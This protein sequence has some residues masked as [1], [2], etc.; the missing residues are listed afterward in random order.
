MG[1]QHTSLIATLGACMMAL[2][3]VHAQKDAKTSTLTAQ[4]Y[5]AIQQLAHRYAYAL[6]T[7]ADNGLMYANLFARD[8]SFGNTKGREALAT[9]AW[10][11]MPEQGSL[12]V[13]HFIVNH[14]IEQTAQGVIGKEYIVDVMFGE[15]G[16]PDAVTSA[17]VYHDEYIKTPEGWRFATRKFIASKSGPDAAPPE[18]SLQLAMPP[19]LSPQAD[20]KRSGGVSSLTAEDYLEIEQ[21][22]TRYPY[23]LDTGAGSGHMYSDL[24]T[25]DGVFGRSIGRDAIA[26]MAWQHMPE[27]GPRYTK[28]FLANHLIQST[29]DGVVGREY[30]MVLA[31][32]EA[33][34][35][36]TITTA[37]LY[38]DV[39]QKTTEGWRFKLRKFAGLKAAFQ[40]TE[41]RQSGGELTPALAPKSTNGKVAAL[42]PLDYVQIRQLVTRSAYAMDNGAENGQVYAD[43]FTPDGIATSAGRRYQGRKELADLAN[44]NGEHSAV[45]HYITNQVIEPSPG[46]A[47]GKSYLVQ[48]KAGENK[49]P[50][51]V[52]GGGHFEDIYANTP[53]GWR[54]K[55]RIYYQSKEGRD[56]AQTSSAR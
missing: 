51:V 20:A 2:V 39:Y 45:L 34:K 35:P 16:K 14:A 27:Q 9:L 44:N 10:Q 18:R 6:D 25:P 13:K 23:A 15:G 28:H 12:Y 8:G 37:G 7:G 21:L 24:F 46:G 50:N 42:T 48:V 17:G 30:V 36:T 49:E 26:K 11:H 22:V 56:R 29:A 31:P 40:P 43:L 32:G 38:E 53:E 4:D 41:I 47:T 5:I 33:G 3:T 52:S 55:S 1:K 19:L 54:L